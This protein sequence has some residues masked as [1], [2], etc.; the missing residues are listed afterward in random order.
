M[1]SCPA[2]SGSCAASNLPTL[3]LPAKSLA[4]STTVGAKTVHQCQPGAPTSTSTGCVWRNTSF[5]KF[6]LVNETS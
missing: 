2:S 6:A 3:T 1:S 5:L 4:I